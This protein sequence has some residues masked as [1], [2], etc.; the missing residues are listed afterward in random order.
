MLSSRLSLRQ[1]VVSEPLRLIAT[2]SPPPPPPPPPPPLAD[3]DRPATVPLAVTPAMLAGNVTVPPPEAVKDKD[4]PQPSDDGLAETEPP[5]L[6][7]PKLPPLAEANAIEADDPLPA[8]MLTLLQT[9]SI[10]ILPPTVR[11]QLGAPEADT[12][13]PPFKG[14]ATATD[15]EVVKLVHTP[16]GSKPILPPT[17]RPQLGAPEEDSV[18]PPLKGVATVTL[19]EAVKLV[20]TPLGSKPMLPPIVRPQLGAPEGDS[21]RPPLKGAATV[22]DPEAVKSAQPPG[23]TG[24]LYT[25][26]I[27]VTSGKVNTQTS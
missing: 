22:T 17:V 15:P 27:G 11:P 9:L 12:V 24:G 1:E 26:G 19:D 16:L 18:R 23:M 10:P 8:V 4:A 25:G 20:H 6:I 5:I 3:K 7:E 2:L 14:E 13:M 21:V